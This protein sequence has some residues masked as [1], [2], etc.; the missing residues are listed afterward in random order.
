SDGA[1]IYQC[2]TD[3]EIIDLLRSGQGVF[4]I[5]VAQVWKELA[6]KVL[7]IP[8]ESADAD[9]ASVMEVAGDELAARRRRRNAG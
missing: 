6:G 8:A 7:H 4:A 1:S 5:A 2:T 9:A 3:Q